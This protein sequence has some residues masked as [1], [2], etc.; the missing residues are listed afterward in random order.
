[1]GRKRIGGAIGREMQKSFC[2]AG[3]RRF[4]EFGLPWHFGKR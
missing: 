1:M 2:H 4:A 3:F